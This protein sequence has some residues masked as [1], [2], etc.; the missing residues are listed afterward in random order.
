MVSLFK[1]YAISAVK[2]VHSEVNRR[3]S[4]VHFVLSEGRWSPIGDPLEYVPD[5]QLRF[6]RLSDNEKCHSK[7]PPIDLRKNTPMSD[8]FVPRDQA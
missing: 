4:A 3:D 2:G 6:S 7:F 8:D 5:R 1:K